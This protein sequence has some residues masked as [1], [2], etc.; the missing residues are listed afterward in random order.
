[1]KIERK[2]IKAAYLFVAILGQP[3]RQMNPTVQ[4]RRAYPKRGDGFRSYGTNEHW[5]E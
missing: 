3:P 4:S 1:M 2:E 5:T